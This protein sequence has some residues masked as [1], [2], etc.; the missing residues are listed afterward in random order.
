M[1]GTDTDPTTHLDSVEEYN[2]ASNSWSSVSSMG[3]A[4]TFTAAVVI[5]PAP[6]PTPLPDP[7][8]DA[9]LQ[10][11]PEIGAHSWVA[12]FDSDVDDA[13]TAASFHAACDEFTQTVSIARNSLGF[14][15]GGYVRLRPSRLSFFISSGS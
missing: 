8:T 1:G 14:T 9:F 11:Q 10:A 15:F 7:N 5:L 3:T 13:S 4:R 2:S 12:C 6:P